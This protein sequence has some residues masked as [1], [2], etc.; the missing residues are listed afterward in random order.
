MFCMRF[1][2]PPPSPV[3][4][5]NFGDQVPFAGMGPPAHLLCFSALSLAAS[6][7]PRPPTPAPDNCWHFDRVRA[8][9]RSLRRVAGQVGFVRRRRA[10]RAKR[11]A[12]PSQ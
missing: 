8:M 10:S 4:P 6:L 2:L 11:R 1:E 5:D 12:Q 3:G 9:D 7:R